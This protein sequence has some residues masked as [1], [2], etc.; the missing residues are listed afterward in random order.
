[1]PR[2]EGNEQRLKQIIVIGAG[3]TGVCCAE[4]LRREGWSVT[5]VDR[6][7]PG[8]PAQ[9][10]YGNAGV[11]ARNAIIPLSVPGLLREV[12]RLLL[13]PD[14]PLFLRWSYLPRLLPWLVPFLRNTRKYRFEKAV[15]ALAETQKQLEELITK[16]NALKGK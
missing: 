12:P 3:I 5:L 13:D 7:R 15:A 1:M 9:A 4:W 16:W 2:G 11:L 6:I 14:S 8:D 10:S